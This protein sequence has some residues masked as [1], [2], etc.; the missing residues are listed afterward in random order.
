VTK[1]NPW[2]L[3]ASHSFGSA[4]SCKEKEIVLSHRFLKKQMTVLLELAVL[5]GPDTKG[6]SA[7]EVFVLSF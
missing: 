7:E 6:L 5:L 2:P 3:L 1:I 4:S